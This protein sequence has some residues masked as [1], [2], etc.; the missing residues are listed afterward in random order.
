MKRIKQNTNKKTYLS[1]WAGPKDT[2]AHTT[3]ASAS[4]AQTRRSP[5]WL[6]PLQQRLTK[7]PA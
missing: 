3:R 1:Y 2:T 4:V 5:G 6:P 7:G